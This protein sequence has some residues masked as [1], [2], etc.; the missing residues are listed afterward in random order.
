MNT[1]ERPKLLAPNGTRRF[2]Y[3]P[4]APCEGEVLETLLF[5][6]FNPPYFFIILIFIPK[7]NMRFE[8]KKINAFATN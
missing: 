5:Q 4:V 7:E 2:F 3:I 1:A 6:I 8:K